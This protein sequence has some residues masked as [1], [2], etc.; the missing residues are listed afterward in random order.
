[1]VAHEHCITKGSIEGNE[2]GNGCRISFLLPH[3]TLLPILDSCV[4]WPRMLYRRMLSILH[5]DSP[6]VG[7]SITD[8]SAKAWLIILRDRVLIVCWMPRPETC[9]SVRLQRMQTL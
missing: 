6:D 4:L 1:M 3:S 5:C 8:G 9:I 7:R 2:Y